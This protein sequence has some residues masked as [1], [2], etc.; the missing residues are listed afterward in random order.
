MLLLMSTV[1]CSSKRI[2]PDNPGPFQRYTEDMFMH[3]EALGTD[4]KFCV[5]LPE[6][7][8]ED[9]DRHYPVVYMLHGYGDNHNSWNGKYLHANTKIQSLEGKG[10]SEM[11]YVFPEGFTSYYCNYYNGKYNYMDMFVN[12]FVP[13]I[14][15]TFRTLA[16]REH[17]A[18]TGYSMGGFG[19]MVLAEKH[20][21]LFGCSAPLSMSFRT[22]AQYMTESAGGWDGQWGKIFGGIGQYGAAR[23]TDYYIAHNPYRQFCDANRAALERVHWFFTC[24]DDEEQLLVAND[25]LHVILRDR[26]F[27]HEFRVANGAHTSSYWMEALSEVLPWMDF[28]MNGAASWPECSRAVYSKQEITA[29]D[30]GCVRSSLFASEGKGMGVFFFHD[31]LSSQEVADAMSVVYTPDTKASF[32]Y[33]PCD[34]G[35]KD[36]SEWMKYYFDRFSLTGS[37]AVVFGDAGEKVM[38]LRAEFSYMVLVEASTGAFETEPGQRFYFAQ[39]DDS[40]YFK[41]MDNLYR[42]CKRSGAVYEY[43]VINGSG[44]ASEDRLREL[45]LLRNYM[46]YQP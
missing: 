2:L 16:D 31:G 12:E 34:L 8:R 30:D 14:D 35:Q 27:A 46:T 41:D 43:R 20:P 18:L 44:N 4:V 25:S 11:I 22:D 23:L 21:E 9:A 29:D 6:S 17:R 5:L 39:T 13:Y 33:L 19:A 37:A 7:Y 45:F 38:P 42:S 10:L 36:I 24:G 15:R 40:A 26:A 1:G 32:V 3:S 28:C